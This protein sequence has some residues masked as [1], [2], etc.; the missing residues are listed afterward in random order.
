MD[1]PPEPIATSGR[2]ATS[3]T[4]R[5]VVLGRAEQHA[6]RSALV[7]LLHVPNERLD[8][9]A[10]L[11]EVS[12]PLLL[13][14]LQLERDQAL[15]SPVEQD[16][17]DREVLVAKLQG[18]LG[19]NEAEVPTEFGEEASHVAQDSAVKVGLE[20]LARSERNSGL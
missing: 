6:D 4:N 13:S 5:F 11:P 9:V 3:A 2:S 19:A 12:G 17:V 14:D 20:V 8:V 7:R 1:D 10:E 15:Q 18:I 16:Q